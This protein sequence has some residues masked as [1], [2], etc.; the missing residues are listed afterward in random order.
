MVLAGL[1]CV[2]LN[3]SSSV[4][5]SAMYPSNDTDLAGSYGEYTLLRAINYKDCILIVAESRADPVA[6]RFFPIFGKILNRVA[7]DDASQIRVVCPA[8]PFS[9]H[10]SVNKAT[11]VPGVNRLE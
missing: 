6:S 9:S 10:P 7:N 1:P 8:F 3:R 2:S 11:P 5:L 4:S